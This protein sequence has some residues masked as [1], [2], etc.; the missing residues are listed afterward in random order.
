[1]PVIF[2]RAPVLFSLKQPKLSFCLH[3]AYLSTAR[4]VSSGNLLHEVELNTCLFP[5][6]SEIDTSRSRELSSSP[7]SCLSG[8]LA[9]TIGAI[10]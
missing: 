4:N 2:I 9:P 1:M 7:A 10:E 3:R 8:A 5:Q 6:T